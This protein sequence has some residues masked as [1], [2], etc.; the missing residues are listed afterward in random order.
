VE[1]RFPLLFTTVRE[2]DSARLSRVWVTG[3]RRCGGG[4]K[5]CSGPSIRWEKDKM[6]IGC[7]ELQKRDA[8]KQQHGGVEREVV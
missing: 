5:F 6:W 7:P 8:K 1:P 2:C 4:E 3:S